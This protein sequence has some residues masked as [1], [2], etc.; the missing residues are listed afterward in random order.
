[1]IFLTKGANFEPVDSKLECRLTNRV[2][3]LPNLARLAEFNNRLAD[4]QS[5]GHKVANFNQKAQS[6]DNG[7]NKINGVRLTQ[8]AAVGYQCIKMY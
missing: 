2:W 1:M 7:F 8:T 5:E 4:Y 6:S 3:V